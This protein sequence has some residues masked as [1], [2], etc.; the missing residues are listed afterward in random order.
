MN[1]FKMKNNTSKNKQEVK[2]Q[3][4]NRLKTAFITTKKMNYSNKNKNP[5]KIIPAHN[6]KILYFKKCQKIQKKER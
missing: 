5:I 6:S 4:S 2:A 3:K 1:K